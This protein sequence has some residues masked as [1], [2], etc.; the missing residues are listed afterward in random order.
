MG[1]VDPE[2]DFPSTSRYSAAYLRHLFKAK[3]PLGP[4]LATLHNLSFYRRLLTEVAEAIGAGSLPDLVKRYA[5]GGGG[6][7]LML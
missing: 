2:S 3:E 7:R 5:G 4:R 6:T 1:P